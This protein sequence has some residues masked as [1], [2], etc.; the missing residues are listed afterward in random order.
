MAILKV[1]TSFVPDRRVASLLLSTL[2]LTFSLTTFPAQA[3]GRPNVLLVLFDD[4]GFSDLGC[5]GGE[6]PTPNLDRLGKGGLR[7]TQMSNSARCCPSR[8]SLL[9][10]LHPGQA[11]IPNMGGELNNQCVTLAEVLGDAGYLTY[12]VGKWHV[13]SKQAI[14]TDR[15]FQ[16]YYGYIHGYAKNQWLPELY[17]R[18]PEGRT[19]EIQYDEGKFYATDVFTDYVLEFLQQAAKKEKPWFLYLAHSSPH[20]PIQAPMASAKPMLDNYRKGWD[21]LRQERFARLKEIGLINHDGWKLTE[22]SLVPV[23]TDAISNGFA[24]KPNPAWA[25]L[26]E[27]RRED[28]A[29]RMALYAAM[30]KHVDDGIGRIV[31]QLK[32]TGSFENTI[33]MILSDNG[34]CY[35]WGPFGFDEGSR[36]GITHLYQGEGLK[37]MGDVKSNMAYGSAWANLCNTP[38]RFYKHFTHQGGMVTP[39]IIHWPS[40]VKAPGRWVRDPAHIMDIMPTLVELANASY[41]KERKQKT[42]LPMEGISLTPTFQLGGTLADRSL[43]YQHEGARAILKKNWKLVY[44]KKFP[45]PITWELYDLS[46]D[47]CETVDLAQQYPERVKELTAEY[48]AWAQH[49]LGSQSK[50]NL[51]EATDYKPKNRKAQK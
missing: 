12:G 9:T 36:K 18:L 32:K 45:T 48:D 27:A 4:L 28:L 38:F 42:I 49:C 26:S 30:V 17:L 31:E 40:G 10:G 3:T 25:S 50:P 16:E 43:C 24:G 19:K 11:G 46:R 8:A 39:F 41:P 14:P 7:F 2:L 23:D 35:E 20:F 15:G 13:G 47:P 21:I 34:A 6:I 33:I 44:G 37:N 22:R 29:H 51:N 1:I 5:Y